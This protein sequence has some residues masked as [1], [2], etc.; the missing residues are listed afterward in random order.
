MRECVKT[1]GSV[2]IP[3]DA[4]PAT[5]MWR[6]LEYCGSVCHNKYSTDRVHKGLHQCKWDNDAPSADSV[7]CVNKWIGANG[8]IQEFGGE[9]C[10][11]TAILRHA[12]GWGH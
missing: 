2:D 6:A 10:L 11:A 4:S 5:C 7:D 9:Q 1:E 3:K 12:H 8:G